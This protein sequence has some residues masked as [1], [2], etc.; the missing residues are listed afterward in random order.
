MKD[1]I[2]IAILVI[3]LGLLIFRLGVKKFGIFT[4][5]DVVKSENME[6]VQLM[7]E[8]ENQ[9]AYETYLDKLSEINETTSCNEA[10]LMLQKEEDNNQ[11]KDESEMTT[12]GTTEK[13]GV[14][15]NEKLPEYSKLYPDL[16]VD[17]VCP[18]VTDHSEKVAYLTFDDG[19][20]DNTL[21]ILEILKE[22]NA[23][24]TFFVLGSTMTKDGEEA[25]KEMAEIGC[26]VGIHTYSHKKDKIY[27]S[28]E[29]Y[30]DDFYKVYTQI[31][32]ITGEKVNIFR[33]PWGSY[34]SYSK[35]I[36]K[37]LVNEMERRGFTYY[38]WNVSAE[39]SVGK[40]TESSIMKNIMKDVTKYKEPVIL[41][42][43][44][45]VND[46]T[47]KMLPKIIDKLIELGYTF[48]TLDHREPCQFCY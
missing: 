35:A 30:L 22:K 10:Y 46:L 11:T 21:K 5:S 8:M 12:S 27:S 13:I 39:D 34:N 1:R 18:N 4:S 9:Q 45:S 28:V 44:S 23:V 29:N 20:S 33:F 2:V 37:N 14:D 48:D 16:Y 6:V 26:T 25:L 41:M 40:P 3:I 38:D 24:A 43:D 32:E 47:V 42:H 15:T 36:K 19:P 31:Y 7:S 17:K